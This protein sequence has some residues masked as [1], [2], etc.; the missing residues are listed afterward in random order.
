MQH[1]TIKVKTIPSLGSIVSGWQTK[2]RLNRTLRDLFRGLA[3][4][5]SMHTEVDPDVTPMQQKQRLIAF[6]YKQLHK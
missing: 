6:Q 5:K 2:Y 1:L 3:K 4:G